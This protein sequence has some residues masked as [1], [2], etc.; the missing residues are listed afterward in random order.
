MND[1]TPT[2]G[3]NEAAP[4]FPGKGCECS[5]HSEAECGCD[6]DWTSSEVYMLRAKVKELERERDEAKEIA[7]ELCGLVC[8]GM[9]TTGENWS[10]ENMRDAREAIHRFVKMQKDMQ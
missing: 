10:I 5:A 6:A 3:W 8:Y 7:E 2:C 4:S 9:G 1:A